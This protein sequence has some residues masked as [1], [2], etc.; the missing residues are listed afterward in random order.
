MATSI[1][2]YRCLWCEFVYNRRDD[3]TICCNQTNWVE[4]IEMC[5]ECGRY[6]TSE[7]KPI[8]EHLTNCGEEERR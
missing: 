8:A 5:S 7:D 1:T 4:E 3:A 2:V 6:F